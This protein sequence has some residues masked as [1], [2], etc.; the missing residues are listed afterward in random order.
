MRVIP[1]K[2]KV[3]K[4]PGIKNQ[5]RIAM[6]YAPC[7]VSVISVLGQCTWHD[8]RSHHKCCDQ[9]VHVH[10]PDGRS[11]GLPSKGRNPWNACD[12]CFL[13]PE[14]TSGSDIC[15]KSH[16][17]IS[18]NVAPLCLQRHFMAFTPRLNFPNQI[19]H[20]YSCQGT[21]VVRTPQKEVW[22]LICSL[23]L[24][25]TNQNPQTKDE[26]L[27][28][29]RQRSS[30]LPRCNNKTKNI[31]CKVWSTTTTAARPKTVW[32]RKTKRLKNIWRYFQWGSRILVREPKKWHWSSL[33]PK[34]TVV[35]I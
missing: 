11:S 5:N 6:G 14:P 26:I 12:L 20:M 35:A 16:C 30:S 27:S 10:T 19:W 3:Y 7:S 2:N 21:C 9:N 13:K 18:Q 1:C 31:F 29:S 28:Q 4:K 22:G 24:S 17:C 32:G 33:H 34:K 23:L 25:K 15:V 8:K